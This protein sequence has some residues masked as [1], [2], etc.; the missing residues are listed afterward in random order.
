MQSGLVNWTNGR[1]CLLDSSTLISGFVGRGSAFGL[2]LRGFFGELGNGGGELLGG[3]SGVDSGADGVKEFGLEELLVGE[4]G[5]VSFVMIRCLSGQPHFH[6]VGHT[7][8]LLC[9]E[10]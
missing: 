1:R 7:K 9:Q 3:K 5:E 10:N 8:I 2:R 6:L 4:S